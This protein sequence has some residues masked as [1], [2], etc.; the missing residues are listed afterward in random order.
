M[1]DTGG[2]WCDGLLSLRHALCTGCNHSDNEA[3]GSCDSA[4]GIVS[5][6][7]DAPAKEVEGDGR[8]LLTGFL[9]ALPY[10][11]RNVLLSGWLV[12]PFT[13]IDLFDLPYKIPKGAA[14]YDA[15]EIKVWGRGYSDVTRYGEGITEWFPDWFRS[16]SLTDKG[17]FLLAVSGLVLLI[18]IVLG[19][20]D[21]EEKR[22]A[23]RIVFCWCCECLLCILDGHFTACPL[24]LRIPLAYGRT[25]L[26]ICLCD[27]DP[28]A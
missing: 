9:T 4:A 14:E 8:F 11:I 2:G 24:W 15:R 7:T 1:A 25:G 23:S 22:P 26:G 10:F 16:L 28:E 5:C 27:M 20:T 21:P 6:D 17:F 19:D 12:Y 3:F 13:S 18:G